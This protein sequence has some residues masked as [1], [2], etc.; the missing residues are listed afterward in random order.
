MQRCS[1]KAKKIETR[2][3]IDLS[4]LCRNSTPLVMCFIH[5]HF[6]K[7]RSSFPVAKFAAGIYLVCP[8]S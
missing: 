1:E 2:F 6:A 3:W 5:F 7:L 8:H 4:L